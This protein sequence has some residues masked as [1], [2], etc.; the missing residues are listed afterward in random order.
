MTYAELPYAAV[1]L[2]GLLIDGKVVRLVGWW[3]GNTMT[4][5]WRC[6]VGIKVAVIDTPATRSISITIIGYI[7]LNGDT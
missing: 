4:G 7:N 3:F 5:W 2:L 1:D 6:A